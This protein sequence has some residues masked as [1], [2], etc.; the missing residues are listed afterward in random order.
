MVS[1]E[2]PTVTS[3]DSQFYGR[4]LYYLHHAFFNKSQ[5]TH[6][7]NALYFHFFI[8]QPLHMFQSLQGHLQGARNLRYR[9]GK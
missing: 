9:N 6:Q 3:R 7:Q 4:I 1:Y 8:L 2:A 5:I